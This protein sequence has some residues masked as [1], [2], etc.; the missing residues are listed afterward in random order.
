V[1]TKLLLTV[2][3]NNV[4]SAHANFDASFPYICNQQVDIA[5]R[6]DANF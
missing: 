4:G 6:K 5:G 1:I 2:D 3:K